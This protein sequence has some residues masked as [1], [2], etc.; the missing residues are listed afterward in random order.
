MPR[1]NQNVLRAGRRRKRSC[2][3]GLPSTAPTAKPKPKDPHENDI[4]FT[5]RYKNRHTHD[6]LVEVLLLLP[7]TVGPALLK[8]GQR[9][10]FKEYINDRL[11]DDRA[12][13]YKKSLYPEDPSIATHP[14]TDDD[15]VSASPL[16]TA[17]Y[18]FDVELEPPKKKL[19]SIAKHF[20]PLYLILA[21]N[22]LRY[23]YPP[24]AAL[25]SVPPWPPPWVSELLQHVIT[26]FNQSISTIMQMP[27]LDTNW[28][29][30]ALAKQIPSFFSHFENTSSFD[31]FHKLQ[32]SINIPSFPVITKE[33]YI[34][35]LQ[36]SI[37]Y[38]IITIGSI[39]YHQLTTNKV[40]SCRQH[41]KVSLQQLLKRI[42]IFILISRITTTSAHPNIT[43]LM[44]NNQHSGGR[45]GGGR[46]LGGRGGNIHPSSTNNNEEQSSIN[47]TN[48]GSST[49]VITNTTDNTVAEAGIAAILDAITKVQDTVTTQAI[50][51]TS[52]SDNLDVVNTRLTHIESS[53]TTTPISSITTN[54]NNTAN[55]VSPIKSPGSSHTTATSNTNPWIEVGS[56]KRKQDTPKSGDI[57][58]PMK[59]QVTDSVP[60]S[61]KGLFSKAPLNG[62]VNVKFWTLERLLQEFEDDDI[63]PEALKIGFQTLQDKFAPNLNAVIIEVIEVKSTGGTY[64][65]YLTVGPSGPCTA[66]KLTKIWEA[67]ALFIK[68]G[69]H[70]DWDICANIPAFLTKFR[71][72]LPPT[73]HHS[74]TAVGV[75][76]KWDGNWQPFDDVLA[77][78]TM[79]NS[80]VSD[81][82]QRVPAGNKLLQL[83]GGFWTVHNHMGFKIVQDKSKVSSSTRRSK[84]PQRKERTQSRQILVLVASDTA[85]SRQYMNEVF[86]AFRHPQS[87][88]PVEFN[89][90][91]TIQFKLF[92]IPINRG[93]DNSIRE[94]YSTAHKSAEDMGN[95]Y[96]TFVIDVSQEYALNEEK[97]IELC[98]KISGVFAVVPRFP[99]GFFHPARVTLV[100]LNDA[101]TRHKSQDW[102]TRQAYTLVP[103]CKPRLPT[104]VDLT[105][106]EDVTQRLEA[107]VTRKQPN[108]PAKMSRQQLDQEMNYDEQSSTKQVVLCGKG[109]L[110]S[111]GFFPFFGDRGAAWRTSGCTYGMEYTKKFQSNHEALLFISRKFPGINTEEDIV[112]KIH[113]YTPLTMTNLDAWLFKFSNLNGPPKEEKVGYTY[114]EDDSAEVA[115]A[116][117][118]CTP[119]HENFSVDRARVLFDNFGIDNAFDI[120]AAAND[121]DLTGHSSP[122]TAPPVD[123]VMM[124]QNPP[125][126]TTQV[127]PADNDELSQPLADM[128]M[129]H[130]QSS[131]YQDEF[132][133]DDGTTPSKKQRGNDHLVMDVDNK[134]EESPTL[135]GE[136][137]QDPPVENSQTERCGLVLVVGTDLITPVDVREFANGFL[138]GTSLPASAFTTGMWDVEDYAIM[139]EADSHVLSKLDSSIGNATIYGVSFERTFV[140]IE[141]WEK[142]APVV[143]EG[144]SNAEN[145]ATNETIRMCKI[146]C[147]PHGRDTLAASIKTA[148]S[149]HDVFACY[150]R[151][152]QSTLPGTNEQA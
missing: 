64:A 96:T 25:R 13:H 3:P 117:S 16:N 135:Q 99:R 133:Q 41:K 106:D 43:L 149:V 45:G 61:R 75:L 76:V 80:L 6:D 140:S 119:G 24:K 30:R 109:G 53:P 33:L 139:I 48:T 44:I 138:E 72:G 77:R 108:T 29:F 107:S 112:E 58:F 131:N 51:I 28:W 142:W 19:P 100:L 89:F 144:M 17:H 37:I 46:G 141:T 95:K 84:N 86:H 113:K 34:S 88:V 91:S 54:N 125:S 82:K 21:L 130:S 98:R 71:F 97:A 79:M 121:V 150:T 137:S 145:H 32:S 152:M 2:S 42:C 148:S 57:K 83:E 52:I 31:A 50:R 70:K 40:C 115:L 18:D 4:Q 90:F 22:L 147:P 124:E 15:D 120:W 126:S 118:F 27:L 62:V 49:P 9:C 143:V 5:E 101:N 67:W 56:S 39:I 12:S 14:S 111:V 36:Q 73:N 92:L 20:V 151:L 127:P 103:A 128:S 26:I 38:T 110:R 122:S 68:S 123:T 78:A 81:A 47:Q 104:S 87:N 146:N 65:G 1:Q 11:C 132:D 63:S 59:M 35:L 23:L 69:A 94:F 105:L 129:Q 55:T 8:A 10:P 74:H 136:K 102:Y 116:R 60:F 66:S 134:A 93:D 7:V 85:L 114:T